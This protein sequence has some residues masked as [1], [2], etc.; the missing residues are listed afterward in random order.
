MVAEL[1]LTDDS[2]E[3]SAAQ[4]LKNSLNEEQGMTHMSRYAKLLWLHM[5]V[6][7]Q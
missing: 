4:A 5:A 3:A 7:R 2:D 1:G 6:L